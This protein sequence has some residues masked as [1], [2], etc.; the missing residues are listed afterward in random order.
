MVLADFDGDGALDIAEALAP[1]H[2]P[3]HDVLMVSAS[4]DRRRPDLHPIDFQGMLTVSPQ[5]QALFELL[6]RVARTEAS[7]LLRGETG[8]GKELAAQ[9]IHALSPRADKPFKAVNCATLTPE[10]AASTLFGHLRGSFTGAVSDRRG[11][12]A[13][14]D[15]GTVF[16][17]EVAELGLDIQARLLRV[18]QERNFVPVGGTD[19]KSVDI[20]LVTATHKSLREEVE[21]RRFREDL[22]YRIRVVPIFIPPLV[23]RTGDVEALTWSF[24]DELNRRSEGQAAGHGGRHVEAIADDVYDMLMG[25][26]W[27]GNVRE[28]RNVIEYAFAVGE[29]PVLRAHEVPPELR[30]ELPPHIK[31]SARD[32]DEEER[33]RIREA[34][35]L[36]G[37]QKSQAAEM[38]GISRTTLWRRMR[39]L[40]LNE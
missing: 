12:F 23:E 7:V 5:M 25:Y 18:L 4:F 37:G 16:L 11:L 19:P 36:A 3:L 27:P 8:T 30:G 2:R 1:I 20:R 17:D 35:R 6:G 39:E 31:K 32:P 24:I 38:L 9:A 14:A 26:P 22:M 21:A 10:L 13:V 33:Q 34:L 15:T 40:K 29:G 28:L